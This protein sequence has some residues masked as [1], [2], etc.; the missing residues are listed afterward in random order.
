MK[1]TDNYSNQSSLSSCEV[2]DAI[3]IIGG[4]WNSMILHTL[5]TTKVIRFNQLRKEISGIS[6]KMLTRQLRELE[7]NGL[8]ARE[9]YAEVPPRVEYSITKLGL[10]VGGIYKQIHSWQKTHFSEIQNNRKQ[11]DNKNQNV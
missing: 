9:V 3:L 5:S 6:Q 4:K 2:R 10:S 8:I 7:R 1:K 11:Y